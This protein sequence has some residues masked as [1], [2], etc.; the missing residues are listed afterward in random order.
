MRRE[1]EAHAAVAGKYGSPPVYTYQRGP[2]GRLYRVGG[3]VAVSASVPEDDPEEARRAG[4]RIA[5]AANA[6]VRPSSA[7]RAAAAS[8]YLFALQAADQA[9]RSEGVPRLDARA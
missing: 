4:R 6:P 1:E 7:D 9:N 8:G 3:S 5:A 2:D